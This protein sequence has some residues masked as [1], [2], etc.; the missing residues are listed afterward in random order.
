MAKGNMKNIEVF[1]RFIFIILI[2]F[3]FGSV[4]MGDEVDVWYCEPEHDVSFN[5]NWKLQK[6]SKQTMI[7]KEWPKKRFI[8]KI[9]K[10]ISIKFKGE[11]YDHGLENYRKTIYKSSYQGFVHHSHQI[12]KNGLRS[13]VF[14]ETIKSYSWVSDIGGIVFT[15]TG[16]CDNF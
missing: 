13:F 6:R 3:S 14:N 16:F 12:G 5:P 10:R 7:V 9:G 15:N 4:S 2:L 11:D 8:M 1:I